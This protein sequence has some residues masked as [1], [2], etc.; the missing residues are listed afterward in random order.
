M[1]GLVAVLAALACVGCTGCTRDE[2]QAA[3]G[4]LKNRGYYLPYLTDGV[5]LSLVDAA[6]FDRILSSV[7]GDVSQ[8][9]LI[10]S[11]PPRGA[12]PRLASPY[13]LLAL[14]GS[15]WYR[16]WL[17]TSK[18][19]A[20]E[21]RGSPV[22][23]SVCL[24]QTIYLDLNDPDTAVLRFKD[25]GENQTCLDGDDRANAIALTDLVDPLPFAFNGRLVDQIHSAGGLLEGLVLIQDNALR[26]LRYPSGEIS[27]LIASLPPVAVGSLGRA[28]GAIWIEIGSEWR[29]VSVA[30][31][32]SPTRYLQEEGYSVGTAP[33]A[34]SDYFYV[35][36]TANTAK[37]TRLWRLRLDGTSDAEIIYEAPDEI[38][39]VTNTAGRIWLYE[40]APSQQK[41]SW[42]DKKNTAAGARVQV[43]IGSGGIAYIPGH[44]RLMISIQDVNQG[45][46]TVKVIDDSGATMLE[47]TN[48]QF[49]LQRRDV[50]YLFEF[51]GDVYSSF[52]G[53]VTGG[54]LFQTRSGSELVG[55]SLK[56]LEGR[57]L[58]TYGESLTLVQSGTGPAGLGWYSAM[59]P[60]GES[61]PDLFAFDLENHRFKLFP[62]TPGTSETPVPFF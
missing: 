6:D 44:D 22:A 15:Q 7:L 19:Q 23:A 11:V 29:R 59:T 3:T 16:I 37:H 18:S 57:Y 14:V 10:A 25:A 54:D 33:S 12:E 45:R 26:L 56:S 58:F 51:G 24:T 1:R 39:Y 21:K 17:T 9:R 5:N 42:I 38:N 60:T 32:L 46:F 27:T 41:L 2:T 30:N 62:K 48:A 31:G 20:P 50:P 4:V 35:L 52:V 47:I 61:G 55:Y 13:A 43:E 36:D 49:E 34:D 8:V 40:D 53:V 28:P